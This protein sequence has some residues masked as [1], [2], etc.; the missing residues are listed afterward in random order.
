MLPLVIALVLAGTP[1]PDPKLAGTWTLQGS[2]FCTLK[3]DGTGTFDEEPIRWGVDNGALVITG[4][5]ETERIPYLLVDDVLTIQAGPVP[6]GLVR[7]GKPGKKTAQAPAPAPEE[8]PT[9]PAKKQ[10]APSGA[11][12]GKDQL[13]QLLLSSAWCSFSFNKVSGA[14]NQS[15]VQFFPNGTWASGSQAETYNSGSAGTVAGQY[16]SGSGGQWAVK[17][18]QLYLS[19]PPETPSLTLVQP[20]S[21][22]ANSN[23]YPII[24]ALGREYSSCN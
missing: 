20:F 15:R 23:G 17:N 10:K 16:N 22:T 18:G 4:D 8:N 12:A 19:D 9:P 21:V 3:A 24:N 14:S 2:P 6:L 5:G 7:A 13:S 1:K 11:A